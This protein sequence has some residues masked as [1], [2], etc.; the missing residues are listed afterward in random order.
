MP[1]C[2]RGVL[3]KC[4]NFYILF[5]IMKNHKKDSIE[6]I[7]NKCFFQNVQFKEEQQPEVTMVPAGIR[8]TVE[9]IIFDDDQPN[10]NNNNDNNNN[11]EEDGDLVI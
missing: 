10:N 8:V 4:P 7:Q 11:I 6:D 3:E 2:G 1:L 9:E 5:K